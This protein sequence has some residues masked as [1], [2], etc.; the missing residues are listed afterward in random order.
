MSESLD[1]ERH[2]S[3]PP[4]ATDIQ[5]FPSF[6]SHCKG[7]PCE[8]ADVDTGSIRDVF[9]ALTVSSEASD[10]PSGSVDRMAASAKDDRSSSECSSS[11]RSGSLEDSFIEPLLRENAD[12]FTM[13]PIR[14]AK[15]CALHTAF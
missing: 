5:E 2:A 13:H 4:I 7:V 12:R 10:L 9:S 14:Y 15:E 6:P 3:E 8:E 11:G 1:T